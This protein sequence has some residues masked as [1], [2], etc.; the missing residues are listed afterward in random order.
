[1][2]RSSAPLLMIAGSFEHA[3]KYP[4]KEEL[5]QSITNNSSPTLLSRDKTLPVPEDVRG[6]LCDAVDAPVGGTVRV[7][8]GDG[9][10]PEVGPDDLD[11]HGNDNK[12]GFTHHFFKV[13]NHHLHFLMKCVKGKFHF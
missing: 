12:H 10:A 8:D 7:A 1:M 9:K 3:Q 11:N 5:L 2:T 13:M 6:L 4:T